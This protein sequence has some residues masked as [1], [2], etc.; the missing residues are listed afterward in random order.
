MP[1]RRRAHDATPVGA[2]ARRLASTAGKEDG[3]YWAVKSGEPHSPLGPLVAQATAEGRT[4]GAGGQPT[5]FHGY[6]FRILEK[7]GAECAGRCA[8]LRGRHAR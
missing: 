2:Y 6:Y 1:T 7:Q 4:I 3:L 5:P 8:E